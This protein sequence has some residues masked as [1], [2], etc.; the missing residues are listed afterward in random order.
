[1]PGYGAAY[2]LRGLPPGRR[3]RPAPVSM[4]DRC[5]SSAPA[6]SLRSLLAVRRR[7]ARQAGDDDQGPQRRGGVHQVRSDC[8]AVPPGR[9]STSSCVQPRRARA[10][11]LEFAQLEEALRVGGGRAVRVEADSDVR[12]RRDRDEIAHLRYA[13]SPRLMPQSQV[14]TRRI[15]I[16]FGSTLRIR[17]RSHALGPQLFPQ[18]QAFTCRISIAFKAKLR[19]RSRSH[20]RASDQPD[21]LGADR[22]LRRNASDDRRAVYDERNGRA[23]R[24]EERCGHEIQAGQ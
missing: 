5:A 18:S 12:V 9:C 16:V 3:S 8:S 14:F 6:A 15:S 11:A 20:R 7:G 21:R 4:H 13:R 1:M 17:S 22:A 23:R 2:F 10:R 24:G 19:V